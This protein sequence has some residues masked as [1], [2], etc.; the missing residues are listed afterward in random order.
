MRCVCVLACFCRVCALVSVIIAPRSL[1]HI[2]YVP[3]CASVCECV[4]VR[5]G[6]HLVVV[7]MRM[8]M[9]VVTQLILKCI[10]I[11]R[12][13]ALHIFREIFAG[14]ESPKVAPS[15]PSTAT[16]TT[17]ASPLLNTTV[18]A[19]PLPAA[20]QQAEATFWR[21][22]LAGSTLLN[23]DRIATLNRLDDNVQMQKVRV[24]ILKHTQHTHKRTHARTHARTRF[25]HQLYASS[26]ASRIGTLNRLDDNV[27]MQKV[28][29]PHTHA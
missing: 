22:Y 4:P 13:S 28:H 2:G 23:L 7:W 11:Y 9:V 18:P 8:S 14:P 21:E 12:R 29:S 24:R 5:G 19:G 16:P 15:A 20:E 17:P 10:R 1:D 26:V 27:Q 25:R 6:I 3:L